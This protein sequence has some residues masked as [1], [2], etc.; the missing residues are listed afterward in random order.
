M[1]VGLWNVYAAVHPVRFTS[2]ERAPYVI[3]LVGATHHGP[4]ILK[5]PLA[6]LPGPAL[7]G[8]RVGLSG[9]L[10]A[11]VILSFHLILEVG[12]QI[13]KL[14]LVIWDHLVSQACM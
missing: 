3:L 9:L 14:G 11:R 7:S 2:M 12:C 5:E 13:I 10:L 1:V 6:E 8:S 4:D